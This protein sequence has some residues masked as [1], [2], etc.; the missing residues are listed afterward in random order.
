MLDY[1]ADEV[2][3]SGSLSWESCQITN[4]HCVS[5][6]HFVVPSILTRNLKCCRD[7]GGCEERS[8][9]PEAEY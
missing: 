4:T 5:T 3:G 8:E 9:V 2:V 7:R 1:L 6:I